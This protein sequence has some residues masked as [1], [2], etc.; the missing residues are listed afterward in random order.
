MGNGS[1][2]HFLLFWDMEN[3]E[4]SVAIVEDDPEIRQ[5]LKILID[6]SPGFSCSSLC[7]TGEKALEDIPISKPDVVLM[8]LQLPGINGIKC[9]LELKDQLPNTNIIILTIQAAEE[10][11]FDSLCAGATGYLLKDTPPGQI[12]QAIEDAH[13]GGSP[14]SPAIARRVVNSFH[15]HKKQSQLSERETEVLKLLCEGENYKSI[16]D[17]LFV[18][19]NTIKAHIKHIYKKLQVH[20]R[21]EAVSKALKDRLI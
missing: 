8:D 3:P 2:A 4:I 20:T 14:M 21:A 1:S 15:H 12:L 19:S 7:E 10:A 6:G 9:T 5:L 17:K 18:S 16:A 11:L 13:K